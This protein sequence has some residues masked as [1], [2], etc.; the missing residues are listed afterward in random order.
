VRIGLAPLRWRQ[1]IDFT[2]ARSRCVASG[3]LT[4]SSEPNRSDGF[5]AANWVFA[6]TEAQGTRSERERAPGA[7]EG[8]VDGVYGIG[9]EV[10]EPLGDSLH[11][12]LHSR[13]DLFGGRRNA[14][15]RL[16]PRP[17]GLDYERGRCQGEADSDQVEPAPPV[18]QYLCLVVVIG[19]R[20]SGLVLGPYAP[21]PG[22]VRQGHVARPDGWLSRSCNAV[23]PPTLERFRRR[24]CRRRC[25]I[26]PRNAERVAFRALPQTAEGARSLAK[27]LRQLFSHLRCA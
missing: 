25:Q 15:Q 14:R 12:S 27:G 17:Q 5:R 4:L 19:A 8:L 18:L 2:R 16:A 3:A 22:A 1:G 23:S 21:T 11:A 6:P 20:L 7:L 24:A 9:R 13:E 10:A 26:I